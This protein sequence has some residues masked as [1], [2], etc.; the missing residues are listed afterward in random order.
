[1]VAVVIIIM[2]QMQAGNLTVTQ[3]QISK[4]IQGGF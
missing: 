2:A 4:G 3:L 1:M